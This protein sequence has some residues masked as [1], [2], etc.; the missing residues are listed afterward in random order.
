MQKLKFDVEH[1]KIEYVHYGCSFYEYD[2][3]K[4]EKVKNIPFSAKPSGG[5][6]ASPAGADGRITY[7]WAAFCRQNEYCPRGNL[8]QKF[9]FCLDAEAHIFHIETLADCH[10][11]PKVK[12]FTDMFWREAEF[13]DFEECV[14]QG[15]DAIEYAYTAVHQDEDVG[16]AM[17]IK[18]LGWDCDSILIMNPDIILRDSF[19]K[20]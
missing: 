1:L 19:R 7:D 5:F 15:M 13:I 17:D 12:L 18:M 9:L 10:C 14:R 3:S 20:K 6:W 11:L 2:R 4:F 16:D 8:N